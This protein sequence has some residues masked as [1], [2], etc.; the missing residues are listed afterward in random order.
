M[1]GSQAQ[2]SPPAIMKV[3]LSVRISHAPISIFIL[4]T[5]FFPKF[6]WI[7]VKAWVPTAAPAF[8]TAAESP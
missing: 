8:P 5:Y 2:F 7:G 3:H 4:K 6:S 1:V